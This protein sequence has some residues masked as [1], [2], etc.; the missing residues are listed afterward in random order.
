MVNLMMTILV[1]ALGLGAFF[2]MCSHLYF[3]ASVC[4]TPLPQYLDSRSHAEQDD[5][6]V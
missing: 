2:L 5:S 3:L 4:D 1:L 6:R